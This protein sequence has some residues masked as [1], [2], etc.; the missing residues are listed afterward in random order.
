MLS[1]R[2]FHVTEGNRPNARRVYARLSDGTLRR[3]T[4]PGM[5][6][7]VLLRYDAG[8]PEALRWWVKVW[9]WLLALI[10]R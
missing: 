9:Y 2:R 10:G 7:N 1:L 3:I 4:D 6:Q 8:T 5:V